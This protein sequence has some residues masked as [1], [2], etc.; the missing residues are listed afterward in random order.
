MRRVRTR[1]LTAAVTATVAGALAIGS[2]SAAH[3]DPQNC[4]GLPSVPEAFV[5]VVSVT[6]ANAIPTVG[7]TGGTVVTVPSVCYFVACTDPTTVTVPTPTLSGGTGPVAVVYYNGST[8]VV[9]GPL[10]FAAIMAL[11]DEVRTT[12][13]ALP[14]QVVALATPVVQSL[15]AQLGP[16][17]TSIGDTFFALGSQ[18]CQAAHGYVSSNRPRTCATPYGALYDPAYLQ[19]RAVGA[20]A[21][22]FFLLAWAFL[23]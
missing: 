21:D 17:G 2:A 1:L 12:A 8:Y 4:V 9:A 5:C 18:I 22:A 23:G 16:L 20:V 10:D 11:I 3:A 13:S 7:G 19:D 15:V 14:S 6:P